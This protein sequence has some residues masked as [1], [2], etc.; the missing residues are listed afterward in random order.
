MKAAIICLVG[1]L[2]ASCDS[3]D[4]ARLH[5]E[6]VARVGGMLDKELKEG[7]TSRQV[8]SFLVSNN[9]SYNVENGCRGNL[10]LSDSA[11]SSG[12]T[13]SGVLP[14]VGEKESANVYIFVHK[15]RGMLSYQYVLSY[16]E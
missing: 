1:L 9:V 8:E 14:I 6:R 3:A 13:Y 15:D 11:C 7:L 16:A 2:L 4:K 12:K 5:E 10:G